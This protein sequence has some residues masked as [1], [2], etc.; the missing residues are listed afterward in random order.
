MGVRRSS[1]PVIS[2]VGVVT[3]PAYISEECESQSLGSSQNGFWKKLYVKSGMSVSPA[4]LSQ[5]ITGQRTAA[6]AKRLVWPMT[7]LEST[8]PPLQPDTYIRDESMNPFAL[9]AS[10]PA[11]RSS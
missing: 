10:A 3:L 6:A 11:I 2:K 4:M 7:Q 9:T 5:S 8:P 1:T